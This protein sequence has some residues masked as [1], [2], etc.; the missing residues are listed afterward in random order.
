MIGI[1]FILKK[2]GIN[3]RPSGEMADTTD[4]YKLSAY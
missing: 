1:Q 2:K 3:L 4:L